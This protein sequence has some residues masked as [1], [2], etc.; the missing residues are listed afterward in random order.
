[1]LRRQYGP[2]VMP[3]VKGQATA[4]YPYLLKSQ[5]CVPDSRRKTIV[6]NA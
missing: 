3:N 1:M 6:M 2:T 4:H 5:E